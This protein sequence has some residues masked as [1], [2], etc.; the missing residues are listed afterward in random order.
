MGMTKRKNSKNLESVEPEASC[1]A[2][3]IPA[4]PSSDA[5]SISGQPDAVENTQ[6][7]DTPDGG[8]PHKMNEE[9]TGPR[10]VPRSTGP[11][12]PQGKRRSARNASKHKILVGR[13]LPEEAKAAECIW[14]ELVKDLNP[15]GMLAQEIVL[16]LV[17]NRIQRR[18]INNY[19]ITE[20]VKAREHCL[21]NFVNTLDQDLAEPW[22]RLM[23]TRSLDSVV[24]KRLTPEAC[25]DVLGRLRADVQERGPSPE[26]DIQVLGC[27]YGQESTA[28]GAL[29]V[30]CYQLIKAGH[31][32]RDERDEK[33]KVEYEQF[34]DKIL[35]ALET[36][37]QF[38][39]DRVERKTT[40]VEAE[41]SAHVMVPSPSIAEA[42]QRY[43][44]ANAREFSR[45]LDDLERVHRLQKG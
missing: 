16:D 23:D 29:I 9:S 3:R 27:V 38:H 32:E 14:E 28:L 20:I 41:S 2:N 12:T 21:D 33:R 30:V 40:M 24:R 11:R 36:E 13:I 26:E 7:Q 17:L 5:P 31:Y 39:R 19:G 4:G 8:S 43:Y 6:P 44:A 42:I 45:L 10:K 1:S 18:R 22:L 35:K 15:R 34:R 37:I 25:I